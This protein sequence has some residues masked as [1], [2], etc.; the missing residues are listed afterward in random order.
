MTSRVAPAALLLLAACGADPPPPPAAPPPIHPEGPWPPAPLDAARAPQA[1]AAAVQAPVYTADEAVH[2]ALASPL[3]LVG[4]GQWTGYFRHLSCIYRNA[5]VLVV[6]MR[7]NR[8][9][10]Y[11]FRVIVA[12]PVR[13]RVEI[14]AD[15]RQRAAAL[16]TV[17]RSGYETFEIS[18]AGPWAGPPQLSPAMS[19]DDITGY[20][21]LRSRFQGGC[22]LTTRMPQAVC[23]HGA[24]YAPPAFASANARFFDAPPDDWYRLV[25]T[26]VAARTPS[27]ATVDLGRVSAKQ[28]AAWAGAVGFQNDIDVTE[29]VLPFVG[30]RDRFAAAVTTGDGGMAYVGT[31]RGSQVVL[32]RTDRA[33]AGKGES[34]L[35]EPGIRQEEA[36][37]VVATANGFYVHAE[38]FV[39]PALKSHH[40]I[41][42]LD[43][44]GKV[45]W[46][47]YPTNRGPTQIP[48][49][50]RAGLTPQGT[51]LVDGYIQLEKDGPVLGWTAEVSADGKTLRDEVGSPELGQRNSKP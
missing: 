34:V 1:P 24:A 20:D 29:Q 47:W 16:S 51:V 7:C 40:R 17:Q 45:L 46:K 37:S 30:Q 42:K 49:F 50:F 31:R 39:D 23:S 43:A 21:E 10:T 6:D 18:G 36:A 12:S 3:A 26:L 2:D 15:A 4:I 13:G 48:Q 8:R 22:E 33:G 27:Y 9:E 44:H 19:Y 38:G 5:Q 28:L 41:V 35:P 11:Q 32:A 14:V 25:T